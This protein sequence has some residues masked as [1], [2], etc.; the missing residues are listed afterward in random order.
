[1]VNL[2]SRVGQ[3]PSFWSFGRI[4]FHAPYREQSVFYVTM[5]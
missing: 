2:E 4:R 3:Y 1:M 5:T